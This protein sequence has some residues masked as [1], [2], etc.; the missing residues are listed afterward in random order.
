[1][2][3]IA[4]LAKGKLAWADNDV[5]IPNIVAYFPPKDRQHPN[6][7][8]LLMVSDFIKW[9][10]TIGQT[11]LDP[12]MGSG[13]TGEACVRTGRKFIGIELDEGHF[14]TAYNRIKKAHDDVQNGLVGLMLTKRQPEASFGI[15]KKKK[16][17]V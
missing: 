8:P 10:S 5:A 15:K 16:S 12:F 6:E 2:V 3:M 4:H 17:R 7:K 9:H 13:T 11:V 1:M 14:Q